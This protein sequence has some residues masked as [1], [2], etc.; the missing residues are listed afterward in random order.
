M[1][2]DYTREKDR[3]KGMAFNGIMMGL[4]SIIIFAAIAP[5]GRKSGCRA[6]FL[7]SCMALTGLVCT[8][9]FLKER[10]P[11][12]K[13]ED[14]KGFKEVARL[15]MQSPALKSSYLCP[16][17]PRRYYRYGNFYYLMG[18]ATG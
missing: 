14:K 1:V 10:L 3:G 7:A 13:K 17:Q 5:I 12:T 16:Y 18:S 9:V 6:F 2:A 11:E 4:A 15:V 8:L